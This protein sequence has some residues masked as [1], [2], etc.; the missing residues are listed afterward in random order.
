MKKRVTISIDSELN[1]KW[2]KIAKIHSISKSG[3]VE[4]FIIQILPILEVE[5]PVKMIS[6]AMKKIS[7]G[8]DDAS[9]LLDYIDDNE[10]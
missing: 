7:A 8:I 5:T 2:N 6:N 1:E 9:S 3:M 4:D 10:V